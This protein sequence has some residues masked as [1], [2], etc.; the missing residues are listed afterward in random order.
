MIVNIIGAG[1]A[2]CE[3]A[4]QLSKRGI[5]VRL[6]EMKPKKF[7]DAHSNENFAELVCS[8]SFR[9]DSLLNAV[10][11][12]KAEMRLLD[13]LILRVADECKLPAGSALAVDREE[14]SR[15]ITEEIKANPLIEVIYDEVKEIMDGPTIIATGPLT[16]SELY[17][18]IQE[19]VK[20]DG[21]Y[22]YDAAAPIVEK[23]SID[24]N[25]AYYK[26]RYDKGDAD[27]INCPMN[28]EEFDKFYDYLINAKTAKLK[29]FEKEIF[30]EGCMPIEVMAKRGKQTLLFGPM[31]P[32]GLE[33]E[34]EKRPYAV[35]QL[36]QDNVA[37]SL[38]NLV[39][40]QTHLT[41]PSQ[42]ELVQMI[43]GLE[44]ASIVRYGVMHRN[45]YINSPLHLNDKYQFIKKPDL[46]FAGQI[47]G[48]EGYVESCASGLYVGINMAKYIK[49]E[50]MYDLSN[51][52]MI[53]ALAYYVANAN[54][55]N[56]QPMNV[57]FGIVKPLHNI[58]K[59]DRKEAYGKR[60]LEK[61]KEELW[62]EI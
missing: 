52:T 4:Y 24:F 34:N 45:T 28:K 15:K 9:S 10:G 51:E 33:K 16:S 20:D 11:V 17:N 19:L 62:Q 26:S 53:G 39:G 47:T 55:E 56:F 48:V 46:F 36:R 60:A 58:K 13:S 59:K 7:S 32:V 29:E 18:S 6:Y 30:F 1:L 54:S 14:F 40:F 22:F 12:L 5:K 38:Y 49:G 44:N 50:P 27:Y 57:N 43:P 31:K 42:K 23:D 41:W 2:G 8:N 25:I 61:I 37:D 35:V 21:L 3:A